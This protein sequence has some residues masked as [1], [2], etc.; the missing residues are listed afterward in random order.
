M[1]PLDLMGG[2]NVAANTQTIGTTELTEQHL[3]L[4]EARPA[5]VV[6]DSGDRQVQTERVET[7]VQNAIPAWL[8]ASSFGLNLILFIAGWVLPRPSFRRGA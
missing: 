2:T 1:S 4:P 7:I 3:V 5:R 8:V 6:Q